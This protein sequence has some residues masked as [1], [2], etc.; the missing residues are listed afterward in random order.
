MKKKNR[1]VYSLVPKGTKLLYT[2][3]SNATRSETE[4]LNLSESDLNLYLSIL[5]TQGISWNILSFKAHQ[6]ISIGKLSVDKE[7]GGP[8]LEKSCYFYA[9]TIDNFNGV[10]IPETVIYIGISIDE[11]IT[12]VGYQGQ[13]GRAFDKSEKQRNW[14][15]HTI[16]DKV[17]GYKVNILP[18]RL[19]S[20]DCKT[21]ETYFI[22]R[23]G[24]FCFPEPYQ[25]P[26][27]NI[28]RDHRD[29]HER[30]E[31]S[32]R[33]YKENPH[34]KGEG[35]VLSIIQKNRWSDSSIRESQSYRLNN[36]IEGL[37]E[38]QKKARKENTTKHFEP[39]NEWKDNFIA[40]FCYDDI[41]L[42]KLQIPNTGNLFE[43]YKDIEVTKEYTKKLESIQESGFFYRQKR[44]DHAKRNLE[45]YGA[46]L[47]FPE[48]REK[49][50]KKYLQ[51]NNVGLDE[52]SVAATN[53][54]T[55]C[56]AY[57]VPDNQALLNHFLN[58]VA[59]LPN[60]EPKVLDLNDAHSASLTETKN[61]S[62]LHSGTEGLQ[63]D[64]AKEPAKSAAWKK[65]ISKVKEVD[66]WES[67]VEKT[68]EPYKHETDYGTRYQPSNF[69]NDSTY[70]QKL[71]EIKKKTDMFTHF[72]RA[73]SPKRFW[74]YNLIYLETPKKMGP[75]WAPSKKL[76]KKL[77]NQEKNRVNTLKLETYK[78]KVK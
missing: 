1:F 2:A 10:Q 62:S 44:R 58:S 39:F 70:L 46:T 15:W 9:H 63:T 56:N 35:G 8:S 52:V 53:V 31:E 41:L 19:E 54:L 66:N 20:N 12:K 17:E 74:D 67:W 57:W 40:Q 25:G 69:L 16:M 50:I 7:I 78:S 60:S 6:Y 22:D 24:R 18:L 30:S 61:S 77:Y 76:L 45:S 28:R 65:S 4:F 37:T 29:P 23:M 21:I 38:E 11:D 26:L 14:L 43:S 75:C 27:V 13:F 55:E 51:E 47:V 72:N 33:F 73:D 68:L 64:S 34:F 71:E 5:Q 3:N 48:Y 32:L 59:K 42:E 36:H 49:K